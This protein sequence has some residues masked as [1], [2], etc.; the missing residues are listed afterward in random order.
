MDR[1][2]LSLVI[3]GA[4]LAAVLIGWCLH[5]V[6]SLLTRAPAAAPLDE[7]SLVAALQEAERSRD[8]AIDRMESVERDLSNR[9]T[10][11]QA[12]LS[13]AMDGLGA[14]RREA[15]ELRAQMSAG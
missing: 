5:W 1:T 10:Q 6:Y 2:D 15:E 9:L 13:A 8:E 12:E 14:A 3:A 11:S 4:L 7:N